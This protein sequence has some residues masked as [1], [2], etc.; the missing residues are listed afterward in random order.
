MESVGVASGR[1]RV[2]PLYLYHVTLMRKGDM[3]DE[4]DISYSSFHL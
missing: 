1:P 3:A 4:V 2:L